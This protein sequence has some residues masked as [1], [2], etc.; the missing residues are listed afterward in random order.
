MNAVIMDVRTLLASRNA[1]D[2]SP[3]EHHAGHDRQPYPMTDVRPVGVQVIGQRIAGQH[4]E[5]PDPDGSMQNAVVI[6]VSFAKDSLFHAKSMVARSARGTQLSRDRDVF[7]RN[8]S[9]TLRCKYSP[10]SCVRLQPGPVF[11][12]VSSA[13][14]KSRRLARAAVARTP[15]SRNQKQAP[16]LQL[17]ILILNNVP[18]LLTRYFTSDRQPPFLLSIGEQRKRFDLTVQLWG[19]LTIPLTRLSQRHR[20]LVDRSCSRSCHRHSSREPFQSRLCC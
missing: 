16:L 3:P 9:T 2:I 13:K 11:L 5:H 1:P 18:H 6:L 14:I 10:P 8:S 15:G 7:T 12:E 4:P 17:A 20:L 19:F